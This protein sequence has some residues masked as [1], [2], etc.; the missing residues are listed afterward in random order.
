LALKSNK[1]IRILSIFLLLIL[2][3]TAYLRAD[4]R[5]RVEGLHAL[6]EKDLDA[7]KK[8]IPENAICLVGNDISTHIL[9]YL[10]DHKG[11]SFSNDELS[12]ERMEWMVNNNVH[13]MY[14]SSLIVENDPAVRP[15]L[16]KLIL[17]TGMMRVY[18]LAKPK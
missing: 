10:L 15:Y 17:D 11:L 1:V 13:F 18:K 14:S 8:A 9:L 7:L 6:L 4:S 12:E 16:K 2:P 3:L 5:W